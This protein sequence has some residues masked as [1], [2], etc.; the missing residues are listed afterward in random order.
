MLINIFSFPPLF[1]L[2]VDSISPHTTFYTNICD[3]G[4]WYFICAFP[5][6]I[7]LHDA[8]FYWAHRLMHHPK[9]FKI[10]HLVHHKSNN[11]SPW[12]TKCQI[13]LSNQILKN[14][15]TTLA[16]NDCIWNFPG[17]IRTKIIKDANE[18][19]GDDGR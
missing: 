14:E 7:F 18:K 1:L 6:M 13:T 17:F 3:Y 12:A 11:Q 2:Y 10:F 8:Y 19:W 16:S 15:K 5:I 4:W 9:L